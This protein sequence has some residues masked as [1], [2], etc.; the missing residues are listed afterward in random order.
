MEHQ[1][2]LKKAA[3]VKRER[4]R[5]IFTDAKG[6]ESGKF[7][8]AI[9]SN[10]TYR[11]RLDKHRRQSTRKT[12]VYFLS[13]WSASFFVFAPNPVSSVRTY[14]DDAEKTKRQCERPL[15]AATF[16]AGVATS[17]NNRRSRS[18]FTVNSCSCVPVRSAVR[19]TSSTFA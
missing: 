6:E 8:E 19:K 17:P 9:W 4:H 3:T 1:H 18:S 5:P 16:V 12:L 10:L 13:L 11:Q 15:Y 7:N 14:R 2:Q